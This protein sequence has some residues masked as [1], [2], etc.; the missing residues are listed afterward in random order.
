MFTSIQI[1]IL[2]FFGFALFT[3]CIVTFFPLILIF[4]L[5]IIVVSNILFINQLEIIKFI[6]KTLKTYFFL[7]TIF[8]P[9]YPSEIGQ[10]NKVFLFFSLN[11]SVMFSCFFFLSYNFFVIITIIIFLQY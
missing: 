7:H 10:H 5:C 9:F 3:Q 11:M 4:I 6:Q 2:I 8:T 1:F